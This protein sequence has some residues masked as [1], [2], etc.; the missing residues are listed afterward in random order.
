MLEVVRRNGVETF[1]P[2]YLIE[3]VPIHNWPKESSIL[4]NESRILCSGFSFSRMFGAK[5]IDRSEDVMQISQ[6]PRISTSRLTF[7][8]SE[9][10][11]NLVA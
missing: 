8:S 9:G 7:L 5:S 3:S 2:S 4:S 1:R 10:D 6:I 11:G